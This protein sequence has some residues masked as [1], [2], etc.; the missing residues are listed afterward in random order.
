MEYD[1]NYTFDS[2]IDED[3]FIGIVAVYAVIIG[4]SLLVGLV[5]Y[6]LQAAGI[7]KM[8]KNQG[9]NNPWLAF[10]PIVN[11][12]PYG[13]LAEKYEKRDG[14]PSAKF[15]IILLILNITSFIATVPMI[16]Y[17]IRTFSAAVM[18]FDFDMT[19]ES[20]ALDFIYTLLPNAV[21]MFVFILIASAVSIA[22]AA[23]SY[24]A[25]WRIFS[26]YDKDNATLY[27]VLSIFVSFLSPI[28]LLILSGKEPKFK[29]EERYAP[30]AWY[31]NMGNV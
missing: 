1:F 12:L 15:S 11:V 27:L 31:N 22:F 21:P 29:K 16:F 7:Y 23:V 13:M 26:A 9:F 18:N 30:P 28:F 19:T 2:G 20:E 25:L 3:F 4:F 6:F 10:I 8:A 24:V 17:M 14:S 5:L